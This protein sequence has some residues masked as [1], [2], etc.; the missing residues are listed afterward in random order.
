MDPILD[1]ARAGQ[2]FL[3]RIVNAIPGFRGYRDKELR[4]DAD[5]LQREHLASRL[6]ECKQALNQAADAATRAGSLAAIND[7]ETARKRLD[8]LANRIRYADR[9]YA[10]FFDP[11]KVD[12]AMLARV[13][14]FDLSLLEGVEAA[15]AARTDVA[16]LL[17]ALEA[18][19]ARLAD[20]EGILAGVK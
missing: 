13:Y 17:S 2:N 11:V 15:R 20:R 9:G 4:R 6:D 18:L 1:R 7:L 14:E 8:R 10:G 12:E 3:E 16:A 5:R 19:D